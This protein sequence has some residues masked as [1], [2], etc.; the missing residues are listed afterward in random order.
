MIPARDL[1]VVIHCGNYR[2]SGQEQTAVMLALMKEVV[3]PG[4]A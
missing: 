4:F 2:R 1:A 3:L